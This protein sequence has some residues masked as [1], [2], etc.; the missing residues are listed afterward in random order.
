MGINRKYHTEI[1]GNEDAHYY[2][3]ER[4]FLCKVDFF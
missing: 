1:P 2:G 3:I 4:N